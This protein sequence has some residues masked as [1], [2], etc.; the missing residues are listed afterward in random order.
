MVLQGLQLTD[1]LTSGKVLHRA[2]S[3]PSRREQLLLDGSSGVELPHIVPAVPV[4]HAGQYYVVLV[5]WV[6]RCASGTE[7]PLGFWQLQ[8]HHFKSQGSS[9]SWQLSTA[10][11]RGAGDYSFTWSYEAFPFDS[12]YICIDIEV[13]HTSFT[14]ELRGNP[15]ICACELAVTANQRGGTVC[16]RHSC[17]RFHTSLCLALAS[18]RQMDSVSQQPRF[19]RA[20]PISQVIRL[21]QAKHVQGV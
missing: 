9:T 13:G 4:H 11:S 18:Q 16:R 10:H 21:D 1:I 2:I 17:P 3:L 12:H 5:L 20:F 15:S 7:C 19:N 14:L 8:M 6:H